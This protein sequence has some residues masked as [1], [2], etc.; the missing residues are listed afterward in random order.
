MEE[1]YMYF[2]FT[3]KTRQRITGKPKSVTLKGLIKTQH[4]RVRIVLD[5]V[6]FD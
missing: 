2:Q 4:S 3:W 1:Q 6:V 5:A